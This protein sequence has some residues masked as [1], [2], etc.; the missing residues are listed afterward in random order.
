MRSQLK[1]FFSKVSVKVEVGLQATSIRSNL[2]SVARNRS[3]TG[4]MTTAESVAAF[5]NFF[6]N[7][8]KISLEKVFF[9]DKMSCIVV[10]DAVVGVVHVV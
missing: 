4:A 3:V 7:G 10:S 6:A 9:T 2:A 1:P 8:G 5:A